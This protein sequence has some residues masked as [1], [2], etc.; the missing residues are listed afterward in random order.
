MDKIEIFQHHNHKFLFI[1]GQLWMWD[2]P[3]EQELQQDLARQTFGDVLVAG[4]GLGIISKFILENPKVKSVVSVENNPA[5]I[6]AMQK[7]GPIYGE[8]II[9]DFLKLPE[10]K[11]YDCV[12]ADT[13][14]EIDAR[15]L[16]E[17]IRN[18]NKALK[19]LKPNGQ[20]LGWGKDF[21]EYLLEK[22]KKAYAR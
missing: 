16:D 20:F 8:I 9:H 3:H 5:V 13:W 21:F 7:L 18:K 10:D 22:Q 12:V 19:L 4:Y 6:E 15:F 14:A 11:K 17:Y 1:D 2:L